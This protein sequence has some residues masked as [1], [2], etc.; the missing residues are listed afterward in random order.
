MK[1]IFSKNTTIGLS[2]I[3]L[4]IM[5][6]LTL[7]SQ[8]KGQEI[9][10][11]ETIGGIMISDIDNSA[12]IVD[13]ASK[14]GPEGEIVSMIVEFPEALSSSYT[15]NLL[16]SFITS[17]IDCHFASSWEQETPDDPDLKVYNRFFY[18]DDLI[19]G[20]FTVS[21]KKPELVFI[22]IMDI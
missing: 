7:G 5:M 21:E 1:K 11:L 18:I 6:I 4:I 8:A 16:D 19:V 12:I 22:K 15:R 20:E 17:N 2:W 13:R 10:N 14:M 3:F 9:T